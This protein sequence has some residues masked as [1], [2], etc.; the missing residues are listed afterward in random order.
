[1]H[2]FG[3]CKRAGLFGSTPPC[4]SDNRFLFIRA[5]CRVISLKNIAIYFIL[6]YNEINLIL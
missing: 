5:Q 4:L 3:Y 2:H 1:M 6:C